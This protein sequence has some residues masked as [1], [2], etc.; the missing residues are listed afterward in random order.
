MRLLPI[1]LPS[2]GRSRALGEFQWVI[3]TS[4]NGVRAFWERLA[5]AGRDA[6]IFEPGIRV[7]AIGPATARALEER[8]VQPQFI[9]EEYVAE[10][11]AA[12]I[13]NVSGQRILLPRA[14][15]ARKALAEALRGGGATVDEVAAYRTLPAE[16]DPRVADELRKGVDV[17][18]FTSSSTVRYFVE[19]LGEEAA[20][21][22][23]AR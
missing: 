18:T 19:L 21:S 17:I 5:A 7:A 2:T 15:I 13:G 22:G 8:G 4:V 14:D 20:S 3:F 6:G 23:A 1:R 11:I 10:A 12:G 9:P 16:P